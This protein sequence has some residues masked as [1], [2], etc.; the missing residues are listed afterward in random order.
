MCLRK[1]QWR[2]EVAGRSTPELLPLVSVLTGRE[3]GEGKEKGRAASW[4][5][6]RKLS[7]MISAPQQNCQS[8][9]G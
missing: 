8:V 4:H 3:G 7:R 5:P 1:I 2:H 6:M 9:I